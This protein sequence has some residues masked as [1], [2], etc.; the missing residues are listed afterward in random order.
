MTRTVAF[1][2]MADGSRADYELLTEYAREF[3]AALPDRI[4]VA[5]QRLDTSLEGYPVSRLVHS[6]QTATRAEAA[7]AVDEM[8]LGALMHDIGDDLAPYNHAA[9]AAEILRP[10]VRAEV[11][12]IIEKH[13]L[14]QSYYYAHHQGG[15]RHRRE[16][17][18]DHLWYA[19]CA[20]FCEWDQASFDPDYATRS[21]DYF[22]PLL[23]R[24]FSQ[25][26][27]DHSA[28]PSAA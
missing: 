14:F 13:G 12:W 9:I 19:A 6:L 7:G 15:D 26:V 10:Y 17:F 5:L 2:Q 1:R 27:R 24:I 11:T 4:L 22:E 21:L 16:Q 8:V 18:K 23:R 3:A 20:R 25:S 28:D